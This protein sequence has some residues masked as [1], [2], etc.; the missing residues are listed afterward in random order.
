MTKFL[1]DT[2]TISLALRR[3]PDENVIRHLREYGTSCAMAAVTWHELRFGVGRLPRGKRQAELAEFLEKV[4]LP[5]IPT[6]PYDERAAAWHADERVRLEKLGKTPP[7]IDGQIAAIALTNGLPI[8]T[9]NPKDF[10]AFK[11]LAVVNWASK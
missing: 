11:G 1:L 10:R 5:T 7:F 3:G 8:V 4:I 2:S 9:A 6:L